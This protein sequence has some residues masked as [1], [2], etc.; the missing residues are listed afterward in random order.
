MNNT[1]LGVLFIATEYLNGCGLLSTYSIR[2]KKIDSRSAFSAVSVSGKWPRCWPGVINFDSRSY[3][4]YRRRNK[5][6]TRHHCPT[7][8]DLPHW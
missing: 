3:T 8:F 2:N 4:L 7:P 5:H 6:A 1:E